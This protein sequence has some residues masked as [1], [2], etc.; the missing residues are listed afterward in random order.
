MEG[1]ENRKNIYIRDLYTSFERQVNI[2]E[3]NEDLRYVIEVQK[4]LKAKERNK[5]F[6]S[7]ET[8][9]VVVGFSAHCLQVLQ[10][11]SGPCQLQQFNSYIN[12][13]F[14]V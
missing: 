13:G 14:G 1:R 10:Q 11:E 7:L 2:L 4:M 12:C 3:I 8:N 6:K 5:G 9:H